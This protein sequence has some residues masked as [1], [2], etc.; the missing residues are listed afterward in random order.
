MKFDPKEPLMQIEEF[1]KT[2]RLHI[3]LLSY[4]SKEEAVVS[5]LMIDYTDPKK[6]ILYIKN[7]NGEVVPVLTESDK[8]FTEF[9][10]DFLE[11]SVD[12]TKNYEPSIW[13]MLRR[14]SSQ[15][16]GFSKEN[17]QQFMNYIKENRN[18][19]KPYMMQTFSNNKRE[20]LIPF[21]TT[22]EVFYD[23]GKIIRDKGI[24]NFDK[25]CELLYN[26]IIEIKENLEAIIGDIS[27]RFAELE[28]K[29][30]QDNERQNNQLDAITA[31]I[32]QINTKVGEVK[33]ELDRIAGTTE[34]RIRSTDLTVN[35]NTNM[36]YPVKIVYR[37]GVSGAQQPANNMFFL[38]PFFL[39]ID[40]GHRECVLRVGH[41]VISHSGSE[42]NPKYYVYDQRVRD[43]VVAKYYFYAV[44]FLSGSEFVV[45]LRGGT[46]YKL[47][48]KYI[49]NIDVVQGDLSGLGFTPIQDTRHDMDPNLTDPSDLGVNIVKTFS[50][51]VHV[52]NEIIIG[53]GK[54]A[55]RLTTR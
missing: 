16:T 28:K 32:A 36:I 52:A 34:K 3:S 10:S 44:R 50:G 24:E 49:E 46:K 23:M 45:M 27:R 38:A 20:L 42:V 25:V 47:W 22:E 48:S 19:L 53:N 17:A 26:L 30:E 18:N 1:I 15:Q 37:S 6:P 2:G 35:G 9:V 7:P 39:T 51:S 33:A 21:V 5:E 11:V 13:C 54:T 41:D 31:S 8:I 4:N 43:S 40:D 55:M 14:D 12:R 29:L